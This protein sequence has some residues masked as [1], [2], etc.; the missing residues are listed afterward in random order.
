MPTRYGRELEPR[1]LHPA[2]MLIGVVRQA[3][4]T[5]LGVPALLAIGARA[6]LWLV[7]VGTAAALIAA[8]AARWIGWSR[9]TYALTVDAVVI[10]SG[11]FSRNRRTIPYERIADVGIEQRPLQRLLGLA[12]VTL[13][14]GGAGADEGALDSVSV[15][16]AERLRQFLRHRR[17]DAG[18]DALTAVATEAGA[19]TPTAGAPIFA[20]DTKRVLL[21]GLFNFS[22]VWI[23][24]GVGALQYLDGPLGVDVSAL[25]HAAVARSGAV[26]SLSVAALAVAVATGAAVILGVGF[27]AGLVRTALRDHGFTL[28]A[29]NGRLRRTRGLFTKSEAIVALPR[30]QLVTIDDGPVRRW[31][32]WSRL[33]AQ[34]LGGKGAEGRQDLAPLA[35]ADEVARVLGVLRVERARPDC[36]EPVARGHIARAMLRR[37]G[38]LA[39]L[40]FAAS[41]A[42]PLALLATPLLLL[43][44]G[45]AVLARRHHRY[46]LEAGLL[47]VQRGVL[48]RT[49]WISPVSR[50]QVVSLRRSWLQRRLGLAT[51]LVDTA[52]GGRADRPDIHDLR[53]DVSRAMVD[54]LCRT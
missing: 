35:R 20:M 38:P 10:E 16:E 36:L 33:R 23:A 1:R 44:I 47:Q 43:P 13:E 21:W 30:V 15:A 29:E 8:G 6:E 7:L 24:V 5:L 41:L 49:T 51:L 52:G 3:P 53:E 28:T 31:L 42:T 40:I 18:Q 2:T 4:S 9:F 19:S 26:R 25:S 12:A 48:S 45:A 14:T 11:V 50:V 54:Q 27:A 46:R 34:I 32:G 39:L 37:V 22:L 17:M